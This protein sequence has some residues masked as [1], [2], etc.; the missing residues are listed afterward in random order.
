[1]IIFGKKSTH[2]LT[3]HLFGVKCQSC[4][5]EEIYMH[6]FSKYVHIYWIPTVPFKTIEISK[7]SFCKQE[8]EEKQMPANY[9][10]AASQIKSKTSPPKWQ[11]IGIILITT[12]PLIGYFNSNST[13]RNERLLIESPVAG[14]IYEYKKGKDYSSIKVGNVTTDSV[15]VYYNEISTN[16]M[17]YA[18]KIAGYSKDSSGLS[19]QALTKMHE[20]GIIFKVIRK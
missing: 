18:S 15:F 6:I 7:C 19:K 9:K 20:D 17:S 14:D 2:L 5:K 3:E 1:M 16:K 8:L 4:G 10:T 13:K 12:L 11:F